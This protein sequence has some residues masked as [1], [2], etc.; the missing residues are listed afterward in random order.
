MAAL[1]SP[2]VQT[3]DSE[4]CLPALLVWLDQTVR[5]AG[6]RASSQTLFWPATS[7]G[8]ACARAPRTVTGM[9]NDYDDW[10]KM[11]NELYAQGKIKEARQCWAEA[12]KIRP[13]SK[14]DEMM[15]KDAIHRAV[16]RGD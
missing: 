14:A 10:M 3:R 8:V 13:L 7:S 15:I 11:G 4:V 2:G 16:R 1:L 9:A 5:A 12:E 6:R